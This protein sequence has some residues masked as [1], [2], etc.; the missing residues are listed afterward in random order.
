M[1]VENFTYSA[2]STSN[3]HILQDTGEYFINCSLYLWTLNNIK[4]SQTICSIKN[5][6]CCCNKVRTLLNITSPSNKH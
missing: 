3:R 4:E 5:H 1:S 6:I 2:L